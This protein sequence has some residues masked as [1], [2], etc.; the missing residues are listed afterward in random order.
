MSRGNDERF[1]TNMMHHKLSWCRHYAHSLRITSTSR[2]VMA[3]KEEAR[4]QHVLQSR[5][6]GDY[7]LRFV[8]KVPPPC[9]SL[10]LEDTH[11]MPKVKFYKTSL[12]LHT[13]HINSYKIIPD[14]FLRFKYYCFSLLYMTFK[15]LVVR[16]LLCHVGYLFCRPSLIVVLIAC[17]I[18]PAHFVQY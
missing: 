17:L 14:C 16:Q 5:W 11:N 18:M 9:F 8:K 7:Y 6:A 12:L 10:Y 15:I 13:E 2:W 4:Y 1:V 3:Q